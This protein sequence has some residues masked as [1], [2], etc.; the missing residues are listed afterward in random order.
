MGK[1]ESNCISLFLLSTGGFNYS[2]QIIARVNSNFTLF[3]KTKYISAIFKFE[4]AA[5]CKSVK[6]GDNSIL[7][8]KGLKMQNSP[9]NKT[10]AKHWQ[11]PYFRHRTIH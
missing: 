7:V 3:R 4:M 1:S 2:L 5:I 8:G 11:E 6:N 9:T 10:V